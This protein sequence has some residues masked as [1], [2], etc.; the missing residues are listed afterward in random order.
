M[1]SKTPC[2]KTGQNIFAHYILPMRNEVPGNRVYIPPLRGVIYILRLPS[3]LLITPNPYGYPPLPSA[4]GCRRVPLRRGPGGS[5]FRQARI[6]GSKGRE[7]RRVERHTQRVL[8]TKG[9]E[10]ISTA[11]LVFM[12]SR[13]LDFRAAQAAVVPSVSP[14]TVRHNVKQPGVSEV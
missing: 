4:Q 9:L 5:A 14:K 12:S 7:Q 1:K 11:G 2:S 10:Y 8:S 6:S 13:M 3:T